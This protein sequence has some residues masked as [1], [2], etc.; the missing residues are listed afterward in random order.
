MR[1]QLRRVWYSLYVDRKYT[2]PVRGF[3]HGWGK[4]LHE[5]E[6]G[7]HEETVAIVEDENGQTHR[8]QVNKVKFINP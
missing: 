3:F 1:T 5:D 6:N 4:Q 8:V 2:E 7:F